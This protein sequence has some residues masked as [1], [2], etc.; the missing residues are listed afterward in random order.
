MDLNDVVIQLHERWK[1]RRDDRDSRCI[2]TKSGYGDEKR[3]R[4]R[5]RFQIYFVTCKLV[6]ENE[7]ELM[8][9]GSVDQP[10]STGSSSRTTNGQEAKK[11]TRTLNLKKE[12]KDTCRITFRTKLMQAVK[13][14]KRT[15]QRLSSCPSG[16]LC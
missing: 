5:L 16:S 11:I 7:T 4:K 14:A 10:I 6:V 15:Y 8:Y 9:S 12:E 1:E 13:S 2:H 3:V